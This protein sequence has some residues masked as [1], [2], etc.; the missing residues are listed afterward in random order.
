VLA[1]L[2]MK[3]VITD[4]STAMVP[5]VLPTE[6]MLVLQTSALVDGLITLFEMLWQRAT[7]LWPAGAP[8]AAAG[9]ESSGPALS[10]EDE[11]ML[12]L[13]ASGLTDQAIARRLGKA[14]RTV[15]RRMQRIMGLLGAQT[16]FQA[17]LQAA[18]RGI[19]GDRD[20]SG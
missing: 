6:Q 7:P 12:A 8:P 16:R 10:A 4:R 1:D 5:L 20:P 15:E 18:G 17:G 2:P 11:H 19:L 14:Q 9:D 3:M 13:A